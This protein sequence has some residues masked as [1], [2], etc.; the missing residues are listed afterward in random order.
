[1]ISAALLQAMVRDMDYPETPIQGFI[2]LNVGFIL[3]RQL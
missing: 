2:F 1:M 3:W